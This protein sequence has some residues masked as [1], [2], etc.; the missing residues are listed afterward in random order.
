MTEIKKSLT[1]F[2]IPLID[3]SDGLMAP[4]NFKEI[5]ALFEPL[6]KQMNTA[7]A[8]FSKAEEVEWTGIG[9]FTKNGSRYVGLAFKT[10]QAAAQAVANQLPQRSVL[11]EAGTQITPAKGAIFK[12]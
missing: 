7:L 2:D 12:A 9:T 11:D 8:P 6:I 5:E 10:T 3:V 4:L 1:E